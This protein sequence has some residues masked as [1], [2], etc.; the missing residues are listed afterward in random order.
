MD[1]GE[2]PQ[3]HQLGVTRGK[4]RHLHGNTSLHGQPPFGR[5]GIGKEDRVAHCRRQRNYG[6]EGGN[7]LNK[8]K[9]RAVGMKKGRQASQVRNMISVEGEES[10]ERSRGI[11]IISMSRHRHLN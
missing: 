5:S 4:G 2:V 9:V 6:D 10:K 8:D 11:T 7:F 3:Q 1:E